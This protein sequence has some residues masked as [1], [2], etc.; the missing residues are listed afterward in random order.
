MSDVNPSCDGSHCVD[1][2]G[3]VRI[4]SLGAGGNLHLCRACWAHENWY[5]KGRTQDYLKMANDMCQ[6]DND[7]FYKKLKAEAEQNWPQLDWYAAPNPNVLNEGA[8][9]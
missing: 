2:K 9:E 4:Y 1:S 8:A 7:D 6:R 5:R 3:E